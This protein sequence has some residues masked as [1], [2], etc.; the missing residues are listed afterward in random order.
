MMFRQIDTNNNGKL[1]WN[2]ALK[3]FQLIQ[4]YQGG[5]GAGGGGFF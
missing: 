2:E 3:I 1:D 4:K 5:G